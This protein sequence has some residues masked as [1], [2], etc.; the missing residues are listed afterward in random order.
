[1]ARSLMPPGG[2]IDRGSNWRRMRREAAGKPE[3]DE[4]G[5]GC[6]RA[7]TPT[8]DLDTADLQSSASILFWMFLLSLTPLGSLR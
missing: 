4:P 2:Q 6:G 5:R 8:R 1:M 3:N 7:A